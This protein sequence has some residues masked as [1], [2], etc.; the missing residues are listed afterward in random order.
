MLIRQNPVRQVEFNPETAHLCALLSREIIR[1]HDLYISRYPEARA[2]GYFT[3]STT[4]ECVYHLALVMH[5]SKDHSEHTACLA[6]FNQAHSILVRLSAYN[7]VAKRALKALNGVAKKWGSGN[8]TEKNG[9]HA[10]M[11][12]GEARH[13]NVR[14]TSPFVQR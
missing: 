3:T 1:A 6:A 13:S 10:G 12:Q 9:G 5:H 7:N 11:R 2:I 4:V 8:I 14:F